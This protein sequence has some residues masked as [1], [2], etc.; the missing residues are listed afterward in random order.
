MKWVE[1]DVPY[2]G[3]QPRSNFLKKKTITS[4]GLNNPTVRPWVQRPTSLFVFAVT[5]YLVVNQNTKRKEKALSFQNKLPIRGPLDLPH[6][7]SSHDKYPLQVRQDTLGRKASAFI[8]FLTLSI[9]SAQ[10]DK[11]KGLNQFSRVDISQH[12]TL[13]LYH[14]FIHVCTSILFLFFA[15][16]KRHF[17]KGIPFPHFRAI[18]PHFFLLY[19][20]W[21]EHQK[22]RKRPPS[23]SSIAKS[24]LKVGAVP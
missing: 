24:Y 7:L 17:L 9:T 3:R 11:R 13:S 20:S 22:K 18:S 21:L 2:Q 6:L 14:I 10:A 19:G 16:L 1:W 15:S 5:L 4:C 12:S 23:A 8:T